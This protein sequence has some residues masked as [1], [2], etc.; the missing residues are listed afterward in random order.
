MFLIACGGG[1]GDREPTVISGN[2]RSVGTVA[3]DVTLWAKIV[4]WIA[5]TASA[6]V[7]GI[8]VAIVNT[9][10]STTT[11][12]HGLFRMDVGQFGPSTLHFS[13]EGADATYPVV[14]PFGGSYVLIDVDLDGSDVTVAQEQAFFRGPITGKDCNQRLLVVLSGERVTYRVRIP[15]ETII[16]NAEGEEIGCRRIVLGREAEVA[17]IVENLDTVV[18][19]E[20]QLNPRRAATPTRAPT[21]TTTASPT[22][23]T[24]PAST[25]D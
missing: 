1:G 15:P 22:A 19:T 5:P 14:L 11:D 24:T 17:S 20:I 23:T 16:R 9:N 18:A 8:T 12:E 7:P 21:A 3:G 2:V 6:Q 10:R 4:R 25:A 13:G